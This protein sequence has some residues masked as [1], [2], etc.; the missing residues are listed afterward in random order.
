M[1]IEFAE[2]GMHRKGDDAT[3]DDDGVNEDEPELTLEEERGEERGCVDEIHRRHQSKRGQD[4]DARGEAHVRS[5]C[6]RST[7]SQT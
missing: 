6:A 3:K 4:E 7:P 5:L 1:C 2:G